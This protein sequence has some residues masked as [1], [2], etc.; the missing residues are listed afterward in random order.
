MKLSI[1]V[2]RDLM[3]CV[4]IVVAKRGLLLD[5]DTDDRDPFYDDVNNE[6]EQTDDVLRTTGDSGTLLFSE[7]HS[8]SLSPPWLNSFGE[9][10]IVTDPEVVKSA[11]FSSVL[12][13]RRPDHTAHNHDN[14]W[15]RTNIFRSSYTIKDKICS[16]VIDS[17]SSRNVIAADAIR[18]L[19]F[20]SKLI[21]C[22][23]HYPGFRMGARYESHTAP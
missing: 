19:E 1:V 23:I 2:L 16:I 22:L 3:R 14:Q 7:S 10:I 8:P 21:W 4:A 6:M 9:P 12:M 15:L 11:D 5:G 17:D 18:K 13:M 20:Q